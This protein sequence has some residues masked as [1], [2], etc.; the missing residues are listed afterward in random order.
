METI[1]KK[2]LLKLIS[3]EKKLYGN[4]ALTSL[5]AYSIFWLKEWN[6]PSSIENISIVN[7]KLF[8]TKFAMVGWPEYPD[9][10]RTNRSV[11][12]MRPKYRN[13]AYSASDKGVFLNE[14]GL[15]EAK[16]LV[17]KFGAPDF[18]GKKKLNAEYSYEESERGKG[19]ARSVHPE[20][21]IKKI[22]SS[23]LF[24]LYRDGMLDTAEAIHLIGMLGVYDHTPSKEKKRKIKEVIDFAKEIDDKEVQQ[25]L[26]QAQ[27]KFN[28]YLN[29]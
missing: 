12:Q 7:A 17:N 28:R 2:D 22:K 21:A 6:I 14:N 23:I 29:K 27:E 25:F 1:A 8:P 18:L 24:N 26:I 9:V 10:N 15:N 5:T 4:I 3:L 20:D 16:A 19:R 13:L 11:L